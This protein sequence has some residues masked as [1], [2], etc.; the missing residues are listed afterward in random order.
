MQAFQKKCSKDGHQHR[1][2]SSCPGGSLLLQKRSSSSSERREI[3]NMSVNSNWLIILSGSSS[4]ESRAR[5]TIDCRKQEIRMRNDREDLHCRCC[6]AVF[7]VLVHHT[8]P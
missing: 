3:E 6:C 2:T 8:S 4:I 1:L 7:C 5:R